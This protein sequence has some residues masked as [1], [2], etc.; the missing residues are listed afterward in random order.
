MLKH[1]VHLSSPAGVCVVRW[2]DGELDVCDD[3]EHF[4]TVK[5]REG[6]LV[7]AKCR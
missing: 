5:H 6:L 3:T 7:V 1:C 4:V 2:G